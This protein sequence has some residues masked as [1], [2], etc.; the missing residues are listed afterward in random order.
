MLYIGWRPLSLVHEY[1]LF[2]STPVR[3]KL[4]E[5]PL[6]AQNHDINQ[7]P[8]VVNDL[9]STLSISSQAES[10][11]GSS[12]HLK[13]VVAHQENFL[14]NSPGADA[15]PGKVDSLTKRRQNQA[16][17]SKHFTCSTPVNVMDDSSSVSDSV[18]FKPEQERES[19]AH[20]FNTFVS[21]YES[22]SFSNP[23]AP[24]LV[25]VHQERSFSINHSNLVAGSVQSNQH[26]R[27]S[28]PTINERP[29]SSVSTFSNLS[30]G[31][32]ED[33]YPA[34][35]PNSRETLAPLPASETSM[36]NDGA[37]VMY[38]HPSSFASLQP[39]GET[40]EDAFR[41]REQREN[42]ASFKDNVSKVRGEVTQG[43]A[44]E[45]DNSVQRQYSTNSENDG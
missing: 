14:N 22:E 20:V 6:N 17:N 1:T 18:E 45:P 28:A 16:N 29:L 9:E 27:G 13:K 25:N 26:R 5:I 21:Q 30:A 19:T 43:G 36:S 2:S 32:H 8:Q 7:M 11:V 38:H 40:V 12:E 39:H 4:E 34:T 31:D 42:Q 10:P 37:S 35:Y 33:P 3:S 41:N 23:S 24:G 15:L 44:T